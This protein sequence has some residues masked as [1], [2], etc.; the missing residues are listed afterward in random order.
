MMTSF[1]IKKVQTTKQ[2]EEFVPNVLCPP[3]GWS[4]VSIAEDITE[5]KKL[6]GPLHFLRSLNCFEFTVA[7]ASSDGL[8]EKMA[9]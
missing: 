5:R 7:A 3:G 6:K 4:G 2:A 9:E 1:A 8:A